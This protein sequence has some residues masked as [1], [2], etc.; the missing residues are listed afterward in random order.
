MA[1]AKTKPIRNIVLILSDQHRQDCIGCYGNPVVQTPHIDRLANS[2]VR[3][4]QAF[5][6]AAICTPARASIQTGLAPRNHGLIFNW[7]F[8]KFRG[9]Q[10]NLPPETRCFAQDLGDAGYALGHFGKWHIGDHNKPADYG[11][12][13]PYYPGYGYPDVHEHYLAYLKSLGLSGFNLTDPCHGPGQT[14]EQPYYATQEGPTEASIPAYLANQTIDHIRRSATDG[15]PFFSSCNFWG[16]HA[17]YRIT[18][19]HL[20]M[21]DPADIDPWPNFH[22]DLSQKP[23]MMRRQGEMFGT[24]W[25]DDDVLRD[26]IAKHYGYVTLIDDQV[27]RIVTALRELDI[28]DE[29]LIVYT[30][31]HGSAVGSY[32][33]WDKGFG[34]YDCLW[35][36]PM[37]FSHPSIEP[38]TSDAF[39]N[40]LDLAPTF[41]DAAGATIRDELDGHS[42]LPLAQG[43]ADAVRGDDHIIYEP[44]GHQ[45]PFWQRVIR[46]RNAKYIYNPTDRDEF[47]DLKNDPGEMH[48]IIDTVDPA[49]LRQMRQTLYEHIVDTNDP[50][51]GMARRALNESRC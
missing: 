49:T 35:R 37:V 6:P 30:A 7:E 25:F 22:A 28:L 41:C 29:T 26:M 44:F 8:C 43:R 50:V 12:E 47:Y 4:T 20:H 1:E 15:K 13:G 36:I 16:P 40:L 38:R 31:D 21:Y 17:P 10:W 24:G 33:M 32:R 48:N 23:Y 51:R 9:G 3:F 27:G 39:V 19:P 5:T 34:G 18:D 45:I 42:L 14:R 11:Y 2:G 46:T